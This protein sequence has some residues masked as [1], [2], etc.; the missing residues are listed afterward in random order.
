MIDKK[1]T[2]AW[3]QYNELYRHAH[4]RDTLERWLETLESLINRMAIVKRRRN[5]RKTA[6]ILE[7][8]RWL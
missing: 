2:P 6:R 1:N 4:R 7:Q 3:H 5:N 8:K